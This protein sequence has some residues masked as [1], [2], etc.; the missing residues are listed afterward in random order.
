MKS[1]KTLQTWIDCKLTNGKKVA[2]AN[3]GM[4]EKR[5]RKLG[6]IEQVELSGYAR[7]H[8]EWPKNIGKCFVFISKMMA[9]RDCALLWVSLV[10]LFAPTRHRLTRTKPELIC[11]DW[12][13]CSSSLCSFDV[14]RRNRKV[15]QAIALVGK[16]YMLGQTNK[17][18]R[19]RTIPLGHHLWLAAPNRATVRPIQNGGVVF[20]GPRNNVSR[21]TQCTLCMDCEH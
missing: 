11:G 15:R 7:R 5:S 14:C 1:F 3:E 17:E 12:R 13:A 21:G 18:T 4:I 8:L 20:G 16:P 9:L 19:K 10:I 2:T 6:R